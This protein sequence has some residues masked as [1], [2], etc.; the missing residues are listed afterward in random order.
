MDFFEDNGYKFILDYQ[1]CFSKF[2]ILRL[3]KTK[4]AVEVADCLIGIFF[5]HGP[6]SLLQ[7]DNGA[8]FSN[9][10]LMARIKELW[11]STRIVHGRPRHPEDQGSVER[12][13]KDFKLMLYARLKDVKKE[14][15]Q[16]VSGWSRLVGQK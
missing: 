6:P 14:Y 5:E 13:N 15:N 4:T 8:E 9:K 2:I 11:T 12:A 10:T 3:L 1:D 16:W 7:I